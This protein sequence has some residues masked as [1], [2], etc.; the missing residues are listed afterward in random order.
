MEEFELEIYQR[1]EWPQGSRSLDSGERHVL[2]ICHARDSAGGAGLRKARETACEMTREK[3][4]EKD[5]H[6]DDWQEPLRK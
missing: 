4:V 3:S 5:S 2:V 1:Q 6:Q